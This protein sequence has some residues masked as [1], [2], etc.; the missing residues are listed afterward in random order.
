MDRIAKDRQDVRDA[1]AK[2]HIREDIFING[3]DWPVTGR[4]AGIYGSRRILNGKNDS[5]ITG[6]ILYL[7]EQLFCHQQMVS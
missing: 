2:S 3:I 6:L 7:Q 5:L 4:V 1:R